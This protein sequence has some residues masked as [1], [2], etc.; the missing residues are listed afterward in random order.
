MSAASEASVTRAIEQYGERLRASGA[1]QPWRLVE[2]LG[3]ELLDEVLTTCAQ[4]LLCAADDCVEAI[5]A[6]EFQVASR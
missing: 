5:A 6:D 2:M 4:T 1:P 3:E